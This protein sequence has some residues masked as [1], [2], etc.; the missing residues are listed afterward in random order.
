[1]GQFATPIESSR[2]SVWSGWLLIGMGLCVCVV[3]VV[4]G[5]SVG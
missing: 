2:R 4:V 5:G 1:M 3:V